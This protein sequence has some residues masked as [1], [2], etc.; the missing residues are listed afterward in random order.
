MTFPNPGRLTLS[1]RLQEEDPV[2]AS[3]QALELPSLAAP[4]I[5][6]CLALAG[7]SICTYL[8]IG[9]AITRVSAL[10]SG[11][12]TGLGISLTGGDFSTTD[13]AGVFGGGGGP[14]KPE[15]ASPV[16]GTDTGTVP[17]PD[18]AAAAGAV[19]TMGPGTVLPADPIL[20]PVL[21][22]R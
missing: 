9:L 20:L 22:S 7:G 8:G 12:S 13:P 3:A 15:T 5:W 18:P 6:T 14:F 19:I 17:P 1:A 11:T 21:S 16:T 4:F 10:G 2:A